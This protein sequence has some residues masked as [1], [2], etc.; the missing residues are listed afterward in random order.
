M[1][2]S[3]KTS[4]LISALVMALLLTVSFSGKAAASTIFTDNFNNENGGNYLLNYTNLANWTVVTGTVDLIGQGSPWDFFPGNGLYLDMDGST[5]AA[6][7]IRSTQLSLLPGIYTLSF[8]LAGN[9]RE[10][11][12]ALGLP[13]FMNLNVGS[14][15]ST[16][17]IRQANDP[18]ALVT[19]IFNVSQQTQGNIIFNHLG[20]D[21][22]GMILDNVKLDYKAAAV[23]EP[24]TM[25][26]LGLGF[27]SLAVYVKRRKVQK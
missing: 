6:G 23:P 18:Y 20:G 1:K 9:Q 14:L 26:L 22:V 27:F 17:Y 12:G 25:L 4:G 13:D 21:N 24:G 7:T 10:N 11:L 3:T 2:S 19:E 8:N 5:N 16:S 15:L